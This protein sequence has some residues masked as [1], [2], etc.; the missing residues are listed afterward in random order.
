MPTKRKPRKTYD[1]FFAKVDHYDV[2]LGA[3]LTLDIDKPR[4]QHDEMPIF[5]YL[6]VLKIEGTCICSDERDGASLY[7]SIYARDPGERDVGTT[8]KN[9]LVLK[10]D[11]HHK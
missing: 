5:N 3:N 11:A 6:K 9:Y 8:L 1:V 4:M 7:L 2:I 10:K